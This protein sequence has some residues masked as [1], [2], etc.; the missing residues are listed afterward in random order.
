MVSAFASQKLS[1]STAFISSRFVLK[2]VASRLSNG[3]VHSVTGMVGEARDLKLETPSEV[4]SGQG[5]SGGESVAVFLSC[6]TAAC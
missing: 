4:S 2:A 1:M 6:I 5:S 3:S